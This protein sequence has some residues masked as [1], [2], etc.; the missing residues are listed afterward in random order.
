M[1]KTIYLEK[2]GTTGKR[3]FWKAE[4]DGTAV[5]YSFGR[6]D[7]TVQSETV[8]YTEGK[9]KGRANETTPE[10]QCLFEAETKARKKL[11]KEYVMV[12]GSLSEEVAA[13]IRTDYDVPLP[14]LAKTYEDQQK[15]VVGKIYLQEK[16]DG[17]RCL[18]NRFTGKM[19]S[20]TRKEIAHLPFV[21]ESVI[22]ATS[23]LPKDVVWVDGELFVT[24]MTFNALQTI[25]RREKNVDEKLASRMKY[26]VFDVISSKPWS[27]RRELVA[28]IKP[29]NTVH[30]VKD[31]C[32]DA[33]QLDAR[34]DAYVMAGFEGAII[35]LDGAGYENKRSSYLIKYKKFKDAEF[36]VTGFKSEKHNPDLLGAAS[37][38]MK[39]GQTFDAR[40]AMS[41]DEKADIWANQKKY[42]GKMATIKY[43]DLDAVSGI[44]RFPVLKAFR[45]ESD[46]G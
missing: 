17:N 9:N 27:E 4:V 10:E 8:N 45:A 40:P 38:Q 3:C 36:L 25:I 26:Y 2:D 24:G 30:V 23:G 11:D 6:V 35:R 5:T 29:S 22:K 28:A 18:V 34:H 13:V 16:L 19:Y 46:V 43:Q 42:I 21:G 7:G 12:S 37:L 41:E 20:R 31:V 1:K 39:D 44:P 15:K 14:M 33:S 32:V